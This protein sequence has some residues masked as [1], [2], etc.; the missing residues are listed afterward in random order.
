MKMLF[1]SGTARG[2]T[3]LRTYALNS[4]PQISLSVDAFLPLFKYFR[5]RL[6]DH[7]KWMN[8]NVPDSWNDS[9]PDLINNAS[10]K[11][12]FTKLLSR[13]EDI[14]I[15]I[16]HWSFIH[17]AIE[18][19]SS[20]ASGLL[21]DQ[22]K[23]ITGES[24][25][26]TLTAYTD[27]IASTYGKEDC[28]YAGFQENWISEFFVPL[29]QLFPDALFISYIR[30]PRA[31]LFSS[32]FHEPDAEKHPAIFSM[33]RHT[34]KHNIL[35]LEYTG[36]VGFKDRFRWTRYEDFIMNPEDYL[37]EI[38]EFLS[39]RTFPESSIFDTYK[40]GF[41]RKLNTPFEVYKNA[42]TNW[43]SVESEPLTELSTFINFYEMRRFGYLH[44]DA[45]RKLLSEAT[46]DFVRMNMKSARGWK[47]FEKEVDA[48]LEWEKSNFT[49]ELSIRS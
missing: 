29:F 28:M 25:T 32:E 26:S 47:E 49:Q 21:R 33:T 16:S 22:V 38:H 42:T 20:L 27:L 17:P 11:A 2:G 14:R 24:F 1:T 41:G 6:V 23:S 10:A 30:D 35:T 4:H 34:R 37:K 31:V 36:L 7:E 39:I 5:S 40:D 13:V 43:D 9:L 8:G 48:Q 46:L 12:S 44:D 18:A 19:R 3:N 15:P 45:E